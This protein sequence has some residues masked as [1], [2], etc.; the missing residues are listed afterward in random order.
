MRWI[1]G[2]MLALCGCD[3]QFVC[4]CAFH[5]PDRADSVNVR[6]WTFESSRASAETSCSAL[7]YSGPSGARVCEIE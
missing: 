4:N 5:L 2:L 6:N 1:V 7:E 3:R